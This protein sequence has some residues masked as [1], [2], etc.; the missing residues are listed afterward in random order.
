MWSVVEERGDNVAAKEV[1]IK[2]GAGDDWDEWDDLALAHDMS[3]LPAAKFAEMMKYGA[4]DFERAG[5]LT[6][7]TDDNGDLHAFIRV[8]A[9][10]QFSMC[11]FAEVKRK[12]DQLD[13]KMAVYE[14]ALRQLGV[15]PT[16]LLQ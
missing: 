15:E 16:A 1:K 6:L 11:A 3:R 9:M 10:L 13:A 8:K 12:F 5:L 4:E 2:D 14:N 7:S